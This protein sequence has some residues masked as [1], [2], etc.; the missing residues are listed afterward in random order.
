MSKNKIIAFYGYTKE[1]IKKLSLGSC[2]D[3][4]IIKKKDYPKPIDYFIHKNAQQLGEDGQNILI[5]LLNQVIEEDYFSG[6]EINDVHSSP[7]CG[8]IQFTSDEYH[9]LFMI[10]GKNKKKITNDDYDKF[11][12]DFKTVRKQHKGYTCYGI[13][14]NVGNGQASKNGTFDINKNKAYIS[15]QYLNK[16]CLELIFKYL[17]KM[18]INENNEAFSNYDIQINNLSKII[19]KLEKLRDN[20]NEKIEKVK[21]IIK[22]L[23]ELQT[24]Y[25]MEQHESTLYNKLIG[26]YQEELSLKEDEERK[27]KEDEERKRKEDEE[28]KRKEDEERKRKEDE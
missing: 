22:Q 7:H 13:F 8:D 14:I 2:Y 21:K 5:T 28:R 4:E 20:N 6:F 9:I 16:H 12:S 17:I 3:L 25:K 1:E 10:E 24:I 18:T 11:D 26:Y 15:R 27:R 23:N 19:K